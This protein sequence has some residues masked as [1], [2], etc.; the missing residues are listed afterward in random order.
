MRVAHLSDPHLLDLA[1]VARSRLYRT[2]RLTGYLTLKLHRENAHQGHIV[3]AMVEDI[4]RQGV[5]HVTIT[6]DLTNLALESEF[7]L[8][9]RVFDRFDLGAADVT[10]IPGNHDVYTRGSQREQRFARYFGDHITSDVPLEVDAAHP[11]G[12]FPFVRLR[13][14]LA[15]I[16]LSTAVARLPLVAAGRAGE[17]Q[18]AAVARLLEHPEVRRRTPVVLVHHPLVNLPGF[19]FTPTHGL[20]E[21]RK[22]RRLLGRGMERG[23]V[24]H[25]H[26]HDRVHREMRTPAGG[27]IHH[28]GATSASMVHPAPHRMAGYN[29]YHFGRD[30]HFLGV[31]AR[32]WNPS[33]RAFQDGTILRGAPC[34]A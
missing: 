29:L 26:M 12:P 27:T 23:L 8:A 15:L 3:E 31:S 32:V 22:I 17:A 20:V 6:G 25:G 11:S 7:A 28:I 19:V 14:P 13:G 18:L 34:A 21:G 16:G 33:T 24:L 10:V 2:K 5:E 30:G 1:G 4:N 9:R